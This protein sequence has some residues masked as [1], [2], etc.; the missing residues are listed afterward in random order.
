MS[1]QGVLLTQ[2]CLVGGLPDH[3]PHTD[4]KITM[5]MVLHLI[6]LPSPL[7]ILIHAF[8]AYGASTFDPKY[9]YMHFLLVLTVPLNAVPNKTD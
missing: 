1:Q 4:Q 5:L 6:S 2:G 8:A 7:E 9:T 3:R